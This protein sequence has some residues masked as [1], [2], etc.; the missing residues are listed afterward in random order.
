MTTYTCGGKRYTEDVVWIEE[1]N[2]DDV[3]EVLGVLLWF[4]PIAVERQSIEVLHFQGTVHFS[5]RHNSDFF[6]CQAEV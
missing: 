2:E 5:L 3:N 6:L 1:Q 4:L